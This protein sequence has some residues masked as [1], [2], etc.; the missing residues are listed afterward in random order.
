MERQSTNGL[1]PASLAAVN[2]GMV[3]CSSC[4]KMELDVS[5]VTPG[6][7]TIFLYQCQTPSC[8]DKFYYCTEH[9][10]RRSK[11][12]AMR[13]H[14]ASFPHSRIILPD[15]NGDCDVPHDESDNSGR[16]GSD[17]DSNLWAVHSEEMDDDTAGTNRRKT[18][19]DF[20]VDI[21]SSRLPQCFPDA[22][23]QEF[24]D[25]A[26]KNKERTMQGAYQ[27]QV[28]V[29]FEGDKVTSKQ[30]TNHEVET[31]MRAA[32]YCH[33]L[34]ATHAGEFGVLL[35][36]FCQMFSSNDKTSQTYIPT[37]R[38]GIETVYT[39]A[40]TSIV[41]TIAYPPISIV[42]KD[43]AY[44]SFIGIVRHHVATMNTSDFIMDISV[45]GSHHSDLDELPEI[46]QQQWRQRSR[47]A[48]AQTLYKVAMQQR[49]RVGMLEGDIVYL[50]FTE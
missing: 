4:H 3:T 30:P 16:P 40:A 38:N 36:M 1:L 26:F 49:A 7:P 10:I 35:G 11:L 34:P 50:Y 22:K 19:N 23:N 9:N 5:I 24:Y 46:L 2:Y 29:A 27:K 15:P 31:H 42:N 12:P 37:T 13:Q 28:A 20:A 45:I 8:R 21:P 18:L 14:I 44:A 41:K 43:H 47:C 32:A 33:R 48:K 39:V 17:N 25:A 6:Y